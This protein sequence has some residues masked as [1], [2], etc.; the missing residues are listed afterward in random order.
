MEKERRRRE[1]RKEFLEEVEVSTACMCTS[2][3]LDGLGSTSGVWCYMIHTAD[4]GKEWGIKGLTS[5]EVELNVCI[6]RYLGA[7]NSKGNVGV[8]G[9][10]GRGGGGGGGG[11]EED[12]EVLQEEEEEE[13]EGSRGIEND[14]KRWQRETE[15]E[16]RERGGE[17]SRM[18]C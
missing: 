6:G 15:E 11:R 4:P 17:R 1:A 10:G 2:S 18:N 8:G 13:E 5:I 12:G 16:E 3:V 7:V 14:R 9:G